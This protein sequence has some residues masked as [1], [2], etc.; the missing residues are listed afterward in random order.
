M[1]CFS[2]G[3][4]KL[5]RLLQFLIAA[6]CLSLY[7]SQAF[8]LP[9]GGQ[10]EKGDAVI[11]YDS[12]TTVVIKQTTQSLVINWDSFDIAQNEN[13]I[14]DQP[15]ETAVM[16]I[17]VSGNDATSILGKLT[18]NGR[19][20]VIDSNGIRFAPGAEAKAAGIV[21]ST[22]SLT[23]DDFMAGHYRFANGVGTGQV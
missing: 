1:K 20:F 11:G 14:L 17:R 7:V 6:A 19:V 21:A 2:S 13:V 5:P 10:V 23:T 18:A 16:L 4:T 9:V 12:P 15:S 22:L 3:H 8:A